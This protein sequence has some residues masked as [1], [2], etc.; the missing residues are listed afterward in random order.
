M[1]NRRNAMNILC[2]D[3]DAEY[4]LGLK[5]DLKKSYQITTAMTLAEG[6][7]ALKNDSCVDVVLLDIGLPD[8]SGIEGLSKIKTDFP[9]VDVVMVTAVKDPKFVVHAVRNGSSDYLVKP[10]AHEELVAILEKLAAVRTI[11]DRHDALVADLNP[12]DTKSRILG[13]SPAFRDLLSQAARLKGHN[14]NVLILGESG[15]G[16]ELLARYIHS[17]DDNAS[18]RP[19]IA[20]NCAAIPEG[21][22]ESEL[23]GHERGS[24]TGAIERKIGKFELANGG[25][26][27]LDEIST[28][29]PDLQAKILRVLQEREIIRVGGNATIHTDFRV[30]AATNI[31]LAHQIESGQFRMDL[32]HRVRVVQLV[33]PPLRERKEDIPTLIAYFLEKYGKGID[34]KK[35]TGSA[36]SKLQNYS[37]PGNIRE[38]ENVIH[39]LTILTPGS[40]IEEKHLPNWTMNGVGDTTKRAGTPAVPEMSAGASYK[41][42]V[43]RAER[44]YIEH[45]LTVCKGD[46]TRAAQ[47]MNIG[48]TTLYAKLKELGLDA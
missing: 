3:D 41:D 11:R 26:I 12:T 8:G 18:K 37:W 46:K 43:N 25:D 10:Y 21:L 20:V 30:L 47:E 33:I 16:K 39:S 31:D 34:S 38:L 36:L 27:F 28:L 6:I 15:T 4:L 7:D 35:I 23:F 5:L 44:T 48:R 17:I 45:I 29:K 42:F 32:Y 9:N 2:I 40:I 1:T 13:S 22:I 19:F 24:F 14:A